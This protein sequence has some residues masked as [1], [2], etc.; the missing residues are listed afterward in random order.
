M[1][2]L[3]ARRANWMKKDLEGMTPLH[4]TTQHKSP[5]CLALLL[6]YM[7][8]GEVDTQDKNKVKHFLPFDNS[9]HFSAPPI[10]KKM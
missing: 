10:N 5:K 1:K 3:L 8:P 2:L 9:W 7:A 6:K 4:L